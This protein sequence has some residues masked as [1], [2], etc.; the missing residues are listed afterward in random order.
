MINEKVAKA[1]NEQIN[2]ELFSSYL[3]LS[4]SAW[5]AA[6]GMPGAANWTKVQAQ[7]EMTHAEK[8]FNYLLE[9]GAKVELT[10]I[11]TP[12]KDWPNPLSVF[13]GVLEH[14]EKVTAL[15]NRLMDVAIAENDH[16]SRIFLQWFVGEQVEEE[17]SAQEIIGQV[18]MAIETKGGLYMIDKELATRVFVPPVA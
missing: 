5:F 9:R 16:A 4:M 3:Y 6:E 14:E 1:I 12:Q 11:D 18:K 7:E 17:A 15:I 13:E 10:A 8:F 2:A